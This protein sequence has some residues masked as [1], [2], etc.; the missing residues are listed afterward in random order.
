MK[1]VFAADVWEDCLYWPPQDRRVL[2]RIHKLIQAIRRDPFA[3]IA[4]SESLQH[5]RAGFWSRRM[6]DEHRMVYR[7]DGD[8]L[9]IAQLRY[10]Y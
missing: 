3:G 9:L 7:I 10:H 1:L 8:G 5:A 2:D 4:K 6:T